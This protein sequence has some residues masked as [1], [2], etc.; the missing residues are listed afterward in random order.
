M[1]KISIT[2]LDY[3]LHLR[4]WFFVNNFPE[5]DIAFLNSLDALGQVEPILI[6]QGDKKYLLDGVK[7]VIFAKGQNQEEVP[8]LIINTDSNLDLIIFIFTKSKDWVLNSAINKIRFIGL[9]Q[10]LKIEKKTIVEQLF[11]LI[12]FEPYH[13]LFD[14]CL[15]IFNLN[16]ACQ[17]FC[18]AK[19]LSFKQCLILSSY[20]ASVIEQILIWQDMLN[21]SLSITFEFLDSVNDILKR[22]NILIQN[23]SNYLGLNNIFQDQILEKTEK[24]AFLRRLIQEKRSPTL[25]PL[26]KEIEN[27]VNSLKF[28]PKVQI[29]WDKTLEKKELAVSF[30]IEENTDL[31]EIGKIFKDQKNQDKIKTILDK[32]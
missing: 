3:S 24:A 6:Y 32:F 8:A 23:L 11:P 7:R 29:I 15:A 2:E 22:D 4:K 26:V 20:D 14:Q 18:F 31:S 5:A 21:L 12:G 28:S 1:T 25:Y 13:K 10:T 9:A 16:E 27:L 30:K 17:K 19:S